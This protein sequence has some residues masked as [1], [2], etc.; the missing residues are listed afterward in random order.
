VTKTLDSDD[1][2]FNDCGVESE[3]DQWSRWLLKDRFGGNRERQRE[4]MN[5]LLPIR[6]RVLTGARLQDQDIV[7]DAGCG[8]GLLG[9]AALNRS[10]PDRQ[11]IFSDIST[12]LLACCRRIATDTG[13]ND[14][15]RFVES[16]LPELDG[17]ADQAVDV[18]M[19]RSVLIYVADKRTAF[20][21]LHRVLR[22]GGRLSLFEPINSFSYPEPPNQL[23]GF[24]ISGVEALAEQVKT[25]I[26]S[27]KNDQS[28]LHDF[29]ERDLMTWAV[30]A[31]FDNLTLHYEAHIGT[32]PDTWPD[33]DTFLRFSPNPTMP[34]LEDILNQALTASDGQRLRQHLATQL[35]STDRQRRL[36]TA[37]LTG[38]GP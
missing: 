21:H 28:S 6:D 19:M 27:S 4:V 29:D 8:D 9:F 23:W 20:T 24:D 30:Q 2:G 18:V 34:T 15:C 12:A 7:L 16:A 10:A 36:A 35:R 33:L 31:G 11:V 14:R 22:P 13:V 3:S 26:R 5:V 25:V 1:H 38:N 17:I 32:D 37:Y